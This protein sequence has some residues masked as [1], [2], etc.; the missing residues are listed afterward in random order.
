[1]YGMSNNKTMT[2]WVAAYLESIDKPSYWTP[3]ATETLKV[4]FAA[5]G[6][7]LDS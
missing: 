3:N 1:M 4:H 2:V 5:K 6:V 7:P